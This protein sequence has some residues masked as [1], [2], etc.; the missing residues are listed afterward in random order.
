ML[1]IFSMPVLI[2]HK[3]QPKT[4]VLLHWC[5]LHGVPLRK[6][7]HETATRTSDS[8]VMSRSLQ[9]LLPQN[10]IRQRNSH[11]GNRTLRHVEKRPD[12]NRRTARRI[13]ASLLDGTP[14]H[15]SIK[16]RTFETTSVGSIW[17]TSVSTWF[18]SDKILTDVAAELSDC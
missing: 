11:S 8:A 4:V 7:F 18:R 12:S 14:T 3:W 16:F 2:R 13:K 1:F 10:K 5:L 15:S 6:E 9:P 17:A